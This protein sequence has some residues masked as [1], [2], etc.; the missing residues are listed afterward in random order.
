M[1]SI[2]AE[3]IASAVAGLCIKACCELPDD[4]ARLL[5][6]SMQGEPSPV[7][8]D[9][10]SQLLANAALARTESVPIC[11]DTG[12]AVIFADLGQE[13]HIT[14]GDFTEAIH[15]GVRRGYISG[16]LRK[17]AVKDPLFN[18]ANT[19]D[20]TPA[21]IHLRLVHGDRLS[22]RLA[23]KGAG[24]E[25][26]SQ[27]TMLTPADGLDGVKN[28]VLKA[29]IAAGPDACPPYVVGV[30]IGGNMETVCLCAKKAC[31]RDA[32]SSNPHPDYAALEAELL[33]LVNQ[34]GIGPQ[35]L[36]GRTTAL[37]VNVE[38]LPTHIACLPVAVNI[39]CHAARHAV[40]VL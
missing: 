17:S 38:W 27:L 28:T 12:L 26:K 14:G 23:P 6:T 9:I 35:G 7:G 5:D 40:V 21:I 16:Y 36:G 22:L 4:V 32:A 33:A 24:S 2:T 11:Q 25:N 37:A 29:V 31:M 8:R 13:L 10:L 30:G 3:T 34:T 18:R 19:G 39:N 1:R 15:E 20:N